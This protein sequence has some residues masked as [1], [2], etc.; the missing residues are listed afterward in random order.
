MRLKEVADSHGKPIYL[1]MSSINPILLLPGALSERSQENRR[2]VL[3]LLYD[4]DRPVLHKSWPRDDYRRRGVGGVCRT[5]GS[6][7]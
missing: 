2:G 3:Y 7:L 6:S 5:V 1:E 4:G